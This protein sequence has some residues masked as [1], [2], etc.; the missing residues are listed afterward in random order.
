MVVQPSGKK[1]WSVYYDTGKVLA[2]GRKQKASVS[3]GSVQSLS[4]E[5]ARV[6]AREVVEKTYGSTAY[7]KKAA[8]KAFEEE[9]REKDYVKPSVQELFE[10]YIEDR[11][12]EGAKSVDRIRGYLIRRMPASLLRM[13]ARE[14]TMSD[15]EDALDKGFKIDSSWNMALIFT[16]AAFGFVRGTAKTRNYFGLPDSNPIA[17]IRKKRVKIKTGY[18]PTLEDLA[19]LWVECENW[20]TPHS[21]NLC[22]AII[23]G[24][25]SRPSEI[26]LRK[27]DNLVTV[28]HEGKHVS[29]LMMPDTK[30]E[31]PHSIVVNELMWECIK[32]ADKIRQEV[33][34]HQE[35][36]MFPSYSPYLAEYANTSGIGNSIRRARA[37]GAISNPITLKHVRHAFSTILGDNGVRADVIARC[38]NHS[39]G[40]QV[41]ERHYGRS[42]FIAEKL[43]GSMVW[44][45]LLKKAISDY[46]LGR[47]QR[48]QEEANHLKQK[49]SAA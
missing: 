40:S 10:T 5:V 47:Y 1:T 44:E 17:D 33:S 35:E 7:Q 39:L 2:N 34:S 37:A 41:N 31:K 15:V 20:M 19:E 4:I 23:A 3:L 26:Q 9:R 28:N 25:G 6:K 24:C 16:K 11:V 42:V 22:R 38:Q 43:E 14:V 18:I 8:V 32:D 49:L 45:Q 30:M 29:L 36:W 21:T 12:T 46:K 13:E 48:Q 27:W